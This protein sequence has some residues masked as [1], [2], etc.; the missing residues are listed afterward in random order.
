[1]STEEKLPG[2]D[3]DDAS[4]TAEQGVLR[5]RPGGTDHLPLEAG[6][7]RMNQEKPESP[8]VTRAQTT[9]MKEDHPDAHLDFPEVQA[10]PPGRLG[11]PRCGGHGGWNLRLNRRPLPTGIEDNREN[12]HQYVHFKAACPNCNGWGHLPE[13]QGDHVHQWETVVWEG[14]LRTERCRECGRKR[15]L[16]TS[17]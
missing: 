2:Q 15:Q 5:G 6:R 14:F 3:Q 1:M 8:R 4:G 11:C 12:R 7:R 9:Y 17:G 16:D 13:D 10:P